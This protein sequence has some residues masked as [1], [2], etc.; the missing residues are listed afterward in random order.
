LTFAPITTSKIRVLTNAAP[1][2]YSRITELEAWTTS[3][4]GGSSS[5]NIHWLVTDQLG[6]PRMV[7]DQSG[8][9]VNVSRHDY[10]PFGEELF[11]GMGGRTT[12][13]G[14]TASDNARQKFTSKERDNE[15]GLDYFGARYYG[16]TQGRFSSA[17]PLLS[18]GIPADPRSWNRYSYCLNAP[19]RYT[20][21][22]GLIWE[23]QT[24]YKDNVS[25][26]TYKWVWQDDPEKGWERVTNFYP[27]VMGPDGKMI[28]L[29]LNPNGPLSKT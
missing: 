21:P 18:S 4:G 22:T 19:L 13:Q 15:T 10:L 20:D 3:S 25:T 2:G 16:S 12:A 14:Y 28:G 5:A 1:D 7:F 26:T 24:T 23:T 8:S 29:R 27:D 9:L 6:T 17:D 11:A